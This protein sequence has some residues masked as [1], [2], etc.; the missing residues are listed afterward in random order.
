MV[1]RSHGESSGSDFLTRPRS[2]PRLL[3]DALGLLLR[4]YDYLARRSVFFFVALLVGVIGAPLVFPGV[5]REPASTLVAPPKITQYLFFLGLAESQL[6]VAVA[7]TCLGSP[8][9][10]GVLATRVATSFMSVALASFLKWLGVQVGVM[11]LLAQLSLVITR[12]AMAASRWLAVEGV[13]LLAFAVGVV[14]FVRYFAIPATVVLEGKEVGRG[15]FKRSADLARGEWRR[16]LATLGVSWLALLAL[17]VGSRALVL[18]LFREPLTAE[19]VAVLVSMLTYPYI[20]TLAALL[21]FDVRTRKEGA[22][23]ATAMVLEVPD[24]RG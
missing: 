12:P 20:G 10:R 18:E 21:Y 19:V 16:I 5:F 6:L 3:A 7:A 17:Q 1:T 23:G 14:I 4:H 24:A 11:A 8:K 13:L 15:A 9:D 2:A 22:A